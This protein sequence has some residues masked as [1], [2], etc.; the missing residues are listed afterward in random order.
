MGLVRVVEDNDDLVS[1]YSLILGRDGWTLAEPLHQSA[2]LNDTAWWGVSLGIV[3]L[4]MPETSGQEVLEFVRT[5]H[6]DVKLLVVTA[7]ADHSIQ[8]ARPYADLILR[9]PFAIDDLVAAVHSLIGS[10]S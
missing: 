9:K 6:P 8:T 7:A 3:D 4:M 1:I 5:R 2:C 10:S